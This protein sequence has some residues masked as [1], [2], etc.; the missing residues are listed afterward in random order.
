MF[1]LYRIVKRSIAE[2]VSDRASVHT[3]NA[4]FGTVFAPEREFFA[5]LVKAAM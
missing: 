1:T 2:G 5:P 4:I 3:R